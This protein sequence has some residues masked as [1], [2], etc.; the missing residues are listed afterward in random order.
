MSGKNWSGSDATKGVQR[1][2][3]YFDASRKVGGGK[4]SQTWG[5]PYSTI[6]YGNVT[7][8]PSIR[9]L[10]EEG[11]GQIRQQYGDVTQY[12]D[13]LIANTRGLRE[14]YLGNESAYTQSLI[15]PLLAQVSQ[16]RGELQRSIGTRGLAGS[17][18][19]EQAMTNFDIDTQRT[20]QDARSQAEFSNL[21]ALTG[22]DSQ[23]AQFMFGK[24]STQS[25]L[26]GMTLQEAQ[27]R[28]KQ[29]MDALGLGTQQ[30]QV[31]IQAFE[32]FQNRAMEN[33]KAIAGSILQGFGISK[34]VGGTG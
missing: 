14:R 12:G 21:Q 30:Q 19:G 33:R 6:S 8:D 24:V 13:E 26:T 17:S 10:Q 25:A 4:G 1:Y 29:E 9:A 11:L 2:G 15:N 23:L 18:F 34:Q 22:I 7:L 3:S 31:M 20:L 32:G 5:T 27:N 28:L 16:R